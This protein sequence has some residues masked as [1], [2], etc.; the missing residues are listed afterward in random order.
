MEFGKQKMNT[1]WGACRQKDNVTKSEYEC[2]SHQTRSRG[3]YGIGNDMRQIIAP[4]KLSSQS[5][6]RSLNGRLNN[7]RNESCSRNKIRVNS[8]IPGVFETTSLPDV[9]NAISSSSSVVGFNIDNGDAVQNILVGGVMIATT[10]TAVYSSLKNSTPV[11][12]PVCNGTGG[13]TCIDCNGTGARAFGGDG[14]AGNSSSN[15]PASSVSYGFE[16]DNRNKKNRAAGESRTM[17][18]IVGRNPREC[19]TCLGVG[20]R[21]CKAC[22]GTGYI[23][24]M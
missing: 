20:M 21:L 8:L 2:V 19:R 13:T 23:K 12:C 9:T 11:I 7:K 24:R 22:E 15:L 1:R 10:L 3:S 18:G 5:R 17:M 14:G 6:V 4:G 16:D